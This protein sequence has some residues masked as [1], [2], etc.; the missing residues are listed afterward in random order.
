[1]NFHSLI[2]FHVRNQSDLS[3]VCEKY[4]APVSSKKKK[5]GMDDERDPFEP[6][7]V[8]PYDFPV[9]I[10]E[11]QTNRL[12]GLV[13]PDDLDVKQPCI[14]IKQSILLRHPRVYFSQ[15]LMSRYIAVCSLE[16]CKIL[17]SIKKSDPKKQFFTEFGS[18]FLKFL[19]AHQYNKKLLEMVNSGVDIDLQPHKS[20][21]R[22]FVYTTEEFGIRIKSY[23]EYHQANTLRI[24]RI[25]KDESE[26]G[27]FGL[28]LNDEFTM[29]GLIMTGPNGE[30]LEPAEAT[31]PVEVKKPDHVSQPAAPA[32]VAAE[33]PKQAS[34]HEG[35]AEAEGDGGPSK[36]DAR[37]QKKAEQ[38][39]KKEAARAK[40]AGTAAAKP[41]EPAATEKPEPTPSKTA[42]SQNQSTNTVSKAETADT[43]GPS[44][45]DARAQKKAEQAAK[46][47]AARAKEAAQKGDAQVKPD[48]P[49]PNP[50][51]DAAKDPAQAKEPTQ[52]K[53]PQKS[54]KDSGEPKTKDKPQ[55]PTQPKTP[56][57]APVEPKPAAETKPVEKPKE[58]AKDSVKEAVPDIPKDA[59]KESGSKAEKPAAK[60]KKYAHTL[61]KTSD[62]PRQH[63][64]KGGL[65]RTGHFAA[66][67]HHRGGCAN[68]T[69]LRHQ[70]LR[71]VPWCA[72]R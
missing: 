20:S 7:T 43:T 28:T 50:T 23:Y 60:P 54:A 29:N 13:E 35:A 15:K 24:S 51:P 33:K 63:H 57:P 55:P 40:E 72:H 69:R 25:S 45:E 30:R 17:D 46:K 47:E 19:A 4:V 18:D 65:L 52:P 3:L 62:D 34:K 22:P 16:V 8:D 44:V 37:A 64:S 36:Y 2:D 26:R 48:T 5:D 10:L 42:P 61:T 39:A 6:S 68:R 9:Y 12:V 70:E 14:K 56:A 49:A 41:A 53:Q 32:P 59:A 1:M 31:K 66:E 27:I 67:K 11:E 21:F 38:A 71:V 58:A